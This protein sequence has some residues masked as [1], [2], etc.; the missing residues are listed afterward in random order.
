MYLGS[1]PN[2]DGSFDAEIKGMISIASFESNRAARAVVKKT[3][4][5]GKPLPI[6]DPWTQSWDVCDRYLLSN[7]GLVDH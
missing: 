4:R 2:N 3:C 1:T 6:V 7:V 5:K